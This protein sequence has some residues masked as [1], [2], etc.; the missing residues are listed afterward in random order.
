M[1][2]AA[3]THK[4]GFTGGETSQGRETDRRSGEDDEDDEEQVFGPNIGLTSNPA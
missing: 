1:G 4:S 2:Q 3:A